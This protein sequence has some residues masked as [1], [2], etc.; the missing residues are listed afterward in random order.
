[1]PFP[2]P[3]DFRR[4]MFLALICNACFSEGRSSQLLGYPT[5]TWLRTG[6]LFSPNSTLTVMRPA[7]PPKARFAMQK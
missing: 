2:D 5:R 6:G 3:E 7:V 1:M 4:G